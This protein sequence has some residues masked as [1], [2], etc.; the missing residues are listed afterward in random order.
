M[1]LAHILIQYSGFVVTFIGQDDPTFT[2]EWIPGEGEYEKNLFCTYVYQ[3]EFNEHRADNNEVI[4]QWKGEF[5][6]NVNIVLDYPT[7]EI[8]PKQSTW[9]CFSS[10]KPL[11]GT[12]LRLNEPTIIPAGTGIFCALGSF[13]GDGVTAKALNYLKPRDHD[14]EIS[15]NAKVIL[16]KSGQFVNVPP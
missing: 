2:R 1:N 14:V 10:Y 16:I 6:S 11:E 9:L 7:V 15:G 4:R 12:F 8:I 5:F 13:T 3:G